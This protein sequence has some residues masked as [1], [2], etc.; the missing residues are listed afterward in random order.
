MLKD[1]DKAANFALLLT[2][3]EGELYDEAIMQ[4]Q[5]YTELYPADPRGWQVLSL[6]YN[7]KGMKIMAE[8]AF[9]KYQEV[10]GQ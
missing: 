5:R 9:K 3:Y 2:Y 7:K 10:T 4:G 6:S 1:D 8:E